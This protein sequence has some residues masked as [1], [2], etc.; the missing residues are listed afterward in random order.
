MAKPDNRADNVQKLQHA[1]QNTQRNLEEAESYLTEHA[2]EI[3]ETERSGIEAK[4]EH[5]RESMQSMRS[6]ISDEANS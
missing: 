5:R 2:A 3:S 4:N 1:V 6:E